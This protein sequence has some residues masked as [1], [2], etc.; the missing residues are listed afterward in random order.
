MKIPTAR[1]QELLGKEIYAAIRSLGAIAERS[2]HPCYLVGGSVRDIVLNVRN[3]DIDLVSDG[4]ITWIPEIVKK[5]SIKKIAR[6]QFSTVK[7]HF[8]GGFFFDIARA[9]KE[10]YPRPASLPLVQPGTLE[11]DASRRDFTINTLLMDISDGSFGTIIDFC[12][13]IV[14]LKKGII[15]VLHDRSFR[16]DPTR[17]FRGIKFKHRFS[18]RFD[19]KTAHLLKVAIERKYLR[20]LTPQ[21]VRREVFLILREQRWGEIMKHLGSSGALRQLGLRSYGANRALS[22]LKTAEQESAWSVPSLELSRL[23]ALVA[24]ASLA[25]RKRFALRI[26]LRKA[27]TNLMEKMAD[28]KTR[29]LKELSKPTASNSAIFTLLEGIPEEGLLFLYSAGSERTRKRILHYRKRLRGTR[30]LITGNDLKKLGIRQGPQYTRILRRV[31]MHKLD[32]KAKSKEDEIFL[33]KKFL[34]Q[35]E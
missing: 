10:S 27:E 3:M 11:E 4:N 7:V 8:S 23:L 20:R 13:G 16:D 21:R 31:L 24:S 17:I 32:R 33:A 26:G 2:G 34:E 35:N 6:S 28:A 14:D 29:L 22:R 18:F 12:N 30:L 1:I 25:E 5:R 15:R 9:R 19:R